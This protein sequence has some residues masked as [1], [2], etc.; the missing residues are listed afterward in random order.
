MKDFV[1]RLEY[2]T[3]KPALRALQPW[4]HVTYGEIRVHYK[5]YLDGGGSAFGQ[6]YI[7]LLHDCGMPRQGRVFEWCAGPAFI[8]FALLGFGLCDTLCLADI[9]PAAVRAC[10]RTIAESGLAD[11]VAVYRSN[12]LDD[13]PPGEQWDL[14]VGNPPHFDWSQIGEIR[15]ADSGWQIHRRFFQTVGRFLKPG[16]VILIQENNHGSTAETFRPMI[17]E[18]GFAIVLIRNAE[19]QLTP[20]TRYYYLGIMRQGEKPPEWLVRGRDDTQ[21]VQK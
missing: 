4:R 11:R 1:K 7:P 8:G 15:I 12:N 13:I 21:K 19:P 16:G 10:R 18:A 3:V 20:Y 5:R 6:D 9:N 17:E 14:V 2:S